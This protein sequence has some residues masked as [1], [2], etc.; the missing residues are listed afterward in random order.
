MFID[1]TLP[2]DNKT[3]VF[4][5]ST[6]CEITQVSTIDHTGFNEKIVTFPSH[7]STHI[8]AP[9]HMV[10]SG[11]SLSNYPIDTFIGEAILLDVRRQTEIDDD[12]N[13]V[14]NN[15][16]VFLFTG[17]S[18]HIYESDY[19][20][21]NPVL[22]EKTTQRL[23]DKKIKILGIDSFTP[24]NPPYRVHKMLL[25]NDILIVENLIDL[26]KITKKRFRCYIFPLKLQ[27][28][29]GAP[30]RVIAEI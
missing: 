12:I 26:Q 2:L 17:Y 25:Q 21:H 14:Q 13:E 22:T 18:Q 27:D 28:A 16:M 29:D 4:P 19:Y 20:E 1:L 10:P 5:G 11:K 8:D 6:K 3:P 23:I 30:C 24:D 15:D 9:L 7:V